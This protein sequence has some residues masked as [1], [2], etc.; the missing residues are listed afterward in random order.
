MDPARPTAAA[1]TSVALYS[2]GVDSYCMSLLC[3]P[4]VLL[5]VR[6]AGGYGELEYARLQTP[7]GWEGRLKEVDLRALGDFE[8]ADSKVIPAR[9]AILALVAANYGDTILMG[10]VDS[11]TGNDKDP[12]FATR[13]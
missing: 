5:Y 11:S 10:S 12:E 8:L 6:M 4:S 3:D 7:P 1:M 13:L 2:G 9:N